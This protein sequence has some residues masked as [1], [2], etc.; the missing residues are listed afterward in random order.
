MPHGLDSIVIDEGLY[1][2]E[3]TY[4]EALAAGADRFD[5]FVWAPPS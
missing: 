4:S 3:F 2:G 5:M 1:D